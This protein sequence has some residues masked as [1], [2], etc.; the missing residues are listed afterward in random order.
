MLNFHICFLI[1]IAQG[2]VEE[3]KFVMDIIQSLTKCA[4]LMTDCFVS[5]YSVFVSLE[6][7]SEILFSMTN[8]KP[9]TLEEMINYA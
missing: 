3:E 9:A 5:V 7:T 2:D 8:G 1:K 4:V 6:G